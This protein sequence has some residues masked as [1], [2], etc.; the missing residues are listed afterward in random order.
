MLIPGHA[1]H[2]F[3][4]IPITLERALVGKRPSAGSSHLPVESPGDAYTSWDTG[5]ITSAGAMLFTRTTEVV[6]CVTRAR[7]QQPSTLQPGDGTADELR[8]GNVLAHQHF[9][10]DVTGLQR[11]KTPE[12]RDPRQRD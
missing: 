8:C 1:D 10:R 11:H 5:S 4:N 6:A 7:D 2:R 3:Q 9:G 12:V